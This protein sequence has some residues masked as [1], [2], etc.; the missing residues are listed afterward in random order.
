MVKKPTYEE[1]EKRIQELERIR[2]DKKRVL[3]PLPESQNDFNEEKFKGKNE[4]ITHT[5]F[6]IANA[7]NTTDNLSDLYRSIYD[8]LDHIIQ[9]SN[10]FIAIV[11]KKKRLLS[12]PFFVDENDTQ[13]TITMG[14]EKYE[15]STSNTSRVI[16]TRKPLFLRKESLLKRLKQKKTIGTSAVIWIG[17]PLIVRDEV[18]GVMV[19]QHYSDPDYFTQK[20]LNLLV[21]V[22]DQVALAIDRK[23]SQEEIKQKEK[24]TR[25]LFSISNAVNTTLDLND[26]YEQIHSLLGEIIDVT[27]FFIAILNSKEGTL[28]F[29]YHRDM[30]DDSFFTILNFNPEDSLTGLVVSKR[31]PVF[32]TRKELKA[33]SEKKGI[34]GPVPMIWMGVPLMIKDEV[35]GVIAVQSYKDPY[36]Y[37][38]HDLEVLASISDQVAIAID[39]K[40]KEDDLRDSEKKYRHLFNNAPAGMY[41]VDFKK[42]K[43]IQVNGL[44]CRYTGYSEE[45]FLSIDPLDLLTPKSK[46]RFLKDYETL[47][48][49]GKLPG[50][51][52]YEIIAKEGH[53]LSVILNSDYVYENEKLIGAR[54]VVHDITE[55]KKI[56]R[57]M[58]QSEKM[59]SVGG[60]AAGMAHEINNPLAGMMQNAQ[61]VYNRLANNL[62][63][64]E[65]VAKDLGISMKSIKRY[66]ERRNIFNLLE[67]INDAGDH[68]ARIVRNMLNFSRENPSE[69]SG[70]NLVALLEKTIDLAKNDFNLQKKYDFKQIEIIQECQPDFPDILCK[71]NNI[72]QVFFNII[73]NASEAMFEQKE[74]KSQLIF[75]IFKNNSTVQIEIED[76]GPGIEKETISRI[77]EPFFTTKDVDKGTGLG[78][79][80]SYFIIA[81]DHGGKMKVESTLGKGT[82][83][84]INLPI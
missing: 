22:S 78:L 61:L 41:E 65:K 68:A 31:K 24:I 10:F 38:K 52:E 34:I 62:P 81:V 3:N 60:L 23:K 77:F 73:K 43:F 79:S 21:A 17:V 75:R 39:R 25:T 70:C 47:L 59:M 42:R 46:N 30:E 7:V 83:F 55:R 13:Q 49:G 26:L 35:I 33:L 76:N 20:D 14:L 63:A 37:N 9:L 56:E 84:I 1:L 2:I 15:E 28:Y 67:S 6:S 80:V 57:M 58:I 71:E 16:S 29:P 11:D 32:L 4:K 82:K 44:L 66:M 69:K 12:F 36:L 27:N 72:Q 18:I 74:K 19:I 45:E 40:Q 64:N 53:K 51:G 48:G 8:S 50:D 5:L 54:V